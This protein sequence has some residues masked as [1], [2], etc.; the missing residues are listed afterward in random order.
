MLDADTVDAVLR[1]LL[2]KVRSAASRVQ[3]ELPDRQ[4]AT[5]GGAVYDCPQVTVSGNSISIE[6]QPGASATD[7][8]WRTAIVRTIAQTSEC[9]GYLEVFGA[10]LMAVTSINGAASASQLIAGK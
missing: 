3:N 8:D 1:T 10:G 5:T 4:Y 9:K 2:G 6:V 7:K